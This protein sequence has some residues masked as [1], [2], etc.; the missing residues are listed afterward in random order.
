MAALASFDDYINRA[1]N[2]YIV[3]RHYGAEIVGTSGALVGNTLVLCKTPPIYTVESMPS[4]VTGFRLT[5]ASLYLSTG[6]AAT[7]AILAVLVDMGTFVLGGSF[8]DGAAMPT[9]TEGNSS[10]QIH[11]ALLVEMTATGSGTGTSITVNYTNQDGNSATTPSQTI[12]TTVANYSCGFIPL[13]TNDWGVRDVTGATR[14]G[15]GTCTIKFWGVI[16]LG[17]F[18]TSHQGVGVV[19]NINF[20]TDTPTPP[21]LN[22]N[23]NLFIIGSGT[24]ARGIKGVLTFVGEQA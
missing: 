4:G 19:S 1:S 20:L 13:A 21:L 24:A 11:S 15:T 18:N 16:P 22:A 9:V 14:T 10:R 12:T 7:G 5:N 17:M 23:D 6:A 8:T 2:G 3:Q